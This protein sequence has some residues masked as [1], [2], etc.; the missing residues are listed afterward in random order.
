[1]FDI[2][3]WELTLIFV[4]GVI[5]FG[6]ERLPGLARKLGLFAARGRAMMRSLQ[7]QLEEEIKLEERKKQ[8]PAPTEPPA[9]AIAA[10]PRDTTAEDEVI[11]ER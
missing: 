11:E 8:T 6:P 3:L 4:L 10:A 7:T 1:M 5:V 2:G 9:K